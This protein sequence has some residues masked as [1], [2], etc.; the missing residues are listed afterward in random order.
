MLLGERALVDKENLFFETIFTLTVALFNS[1][2]WVR[3]SYIVWKAFP[4]FGADH[5]RRNPIR[6]H[7]LVPS[8]RTTSS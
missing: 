7:S 1:Y 4:F 8:R 6:T 2:D 3:M 5:L